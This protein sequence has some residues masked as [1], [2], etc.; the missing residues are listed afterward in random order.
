ML[1]YNIVCACAYCSHGRPGEDD[2]VLC[3][4]HGIVNPWERCPRFQYDPL[5]RIPEAEPVP[6]TDV[7]PASFDL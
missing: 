4:H 3:V 1:I 7:D 5:R 2:S 6:Q